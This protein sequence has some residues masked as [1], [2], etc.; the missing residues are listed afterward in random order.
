MARDCRR[1]PC[2]GDSC[3]WLTIASGNAN[4]AHSD[5]VY[6]VDA[7]RLVARRHHCWRPPFA[8]QVQIRLALVS[9]L[10]MTDAVRHVRRAVCTELVIVQ[11]NF[12]FLRLLPS[13]NLLGL[14]DHLRGRSLLVIS[15]ERNKLQICLALM[16]QCFVYIVISFSLSNLI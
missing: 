8:S 9:K 10:G 4:Y 16:F 12:A 2:Y 13:A 5:V 15:S 3:R 7:V 6:F 14:F 1:R 11:S